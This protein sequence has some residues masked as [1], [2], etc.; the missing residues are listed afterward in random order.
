MVFSEIMKKVKVPEKIA[1]LLQLFFA[2]NFSGCHSTGN[3][4][5]EVRDEFCFFHYLSR[6]SGA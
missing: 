3:R 5:S 1:I 2:H 6:I 4:M